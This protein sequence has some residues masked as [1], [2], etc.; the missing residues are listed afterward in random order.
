MTEHDKRLLEEAR[1]LRWEDIDESK[2]ETEEGREEL[3]RIIMSKYHRD[4]YKAGMI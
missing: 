2:A 1:H 3:H 4:E